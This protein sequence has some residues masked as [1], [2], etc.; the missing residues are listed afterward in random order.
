R[1]E[2]GARALGNRSILAD[3]RSVQ[4]RDKVNASVKYREYWRPF[5]PSILSERMSTYFDRYT[6]APFMIISFVANE[7]LKRDAP[8]TVHVDGTA[9]VQS[10]RKE[11]NA[12]F[13]RLLLQFESI[14]GVPILLN[15]SFNIKGESIVCTV[16]D[17]LRTFWSTSLDVLAIGSFLV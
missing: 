9:R 15:T 14:T 11:V 13:H 2:A 4:N 5:C 10:V 7:R 3:P 8:A 6:D 12:R 1:M 17:A 16:G